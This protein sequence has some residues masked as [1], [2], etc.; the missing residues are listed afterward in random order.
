[1]ATEVQRRRGTAS[2]HNTFTGAAGEVTVNTTNDSLHVHDGATAGGFEA[3]RAD[4]DNAQNDVITNDMLSLNANDGEIKKAINSD[5]APPIYACRAWVNF[6]G[7]G[8]VSIRDSGNVSSITDNVTGDYTVNFATAMPDNDYAA[9]MSSINSSSANGQTV[10]LQLKNTSAV[11]T[12]SFDVTFKATASV[13]VFDV[14]IANIS[15][16]R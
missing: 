12:S 6:N 3:M 8:T 15:V 5:N 1:M 9:T 4:A 11:L 14:L 13:G 16:F 2:E 10:V 7:T